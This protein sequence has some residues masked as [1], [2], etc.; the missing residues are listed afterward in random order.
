[1]GGKDEGRDEA[2]RRN[3]KIVTVDWKIITP[4]GVV[5]VR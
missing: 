3:G 2:S 1:M 4:G 5:T